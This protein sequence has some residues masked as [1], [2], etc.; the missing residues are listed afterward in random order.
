MG[1]GVAVRL[2]VSAM[3]VT[4]L[5]TAL[6]GGASA[7]SN[8]PILMRFYAHGDASAGE[9]QLHQ[10]LTGA[11]MSMDRKAP[12]SDVPKSMGL[13]A[14]AGAPNQNCAG[15]PY[16]PVW[17]G[18]IGGRITGD[19][20]FDFHVMSSTGGKVEI[21]VWPD[22]EVTGCDEDYRDPYAITR[23]A[24]PEG[25]GAVNAVM[26]DVDF[27]AATNVMVQVTPLRAGITQGRIL[28][29]SKEADTSLTFHCTPLWGDSSC[30]P[31]D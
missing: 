21:R 12:T 24:L 11:Y 30:R 15:S 16:F 31:Y 17:V 22:M 1:R 2:L 28:Y 10:A 20:V 27:E 4:V 19:I 23:V 9:A 7:T 26:N 13:V 6:T 18:E 14:A 5:S 29:D 8:E 3:C 25:S